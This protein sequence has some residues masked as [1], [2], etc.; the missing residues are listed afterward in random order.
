MISDQ[1]SPSQYEDV[2]YETEHT[3]R[4]K[5]LAFNDPVHSTSLKDTLQTQVRISLM[6]YYLIYSI[7]AQKL[8]IFSKL[9]VGRVAKNSRGYSI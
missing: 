4:Q 3:Q 6:S 2:D 5:R 7:I 9:L 8:K 1:P